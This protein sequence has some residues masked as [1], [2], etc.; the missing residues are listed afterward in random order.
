MLEAHLQQLQAEGYMQLPLALNT[1]DTTADLQHIMPRCGLLSASDVQVL[2]VSDG[3][4]Q[5]LEWDSLVIAA[6]HVD[7]AP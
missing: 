5:L 4:I 1:Q 3:S 6:V 7:S 2:I